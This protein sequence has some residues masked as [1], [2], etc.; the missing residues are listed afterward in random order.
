MRAIDHGVDDH[1]DDAMTS[2]TT[3]TPL[4]DPGALISGAFDYPGD[5]D[6]FTV[7]VQANRIYAFTETLAVDIYQ[8]VN[9]ATGSFIGLTD[10]ESVRFETTTAQSLYVCVRAYASSNLAPWSMRVVDVGV[11]DQPDTATTTTT[12]LTPTATLAGSL[13]VASDVDCVAVPVVA[14]RVYGFAETTAL[15][16]TQSLVSATVTVQGST[17]AESFRV[18]ASAT[19][20][21]SWC[22]RGYSSASL[23]P[24]SLTVTDYGPDDHGDDRATATPLAIDAPPVTGEVQLTTDVDFFTFNVTSVLALRVVTTGVATSVQVQSATGAVI[25][26][27]TGP[28]TL[29]FAAPSSGTYFVRV[30]SSSLGAYT[31]TVGN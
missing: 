29:A 6:C 31:V 28:G 4:P 10:A 19:E 23:A 18:K 14:G 17:D 12:T 1:P 26:S 11:D 16:I 15:D 30:S 20:T 5:V 24:W 2:V 27:G 13:D 22:V 9:T 25:A 21:L 3:V 8:A 7:P